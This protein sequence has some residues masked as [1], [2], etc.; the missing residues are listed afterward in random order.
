M[1]VRHAKSAKATWLLIFLAGC[2]TGPDVGK[3]WSECLAFGGS[4]KFI[5]TESTRQAECHRATTP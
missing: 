4:P 1:V 3:A 5:A 2:G